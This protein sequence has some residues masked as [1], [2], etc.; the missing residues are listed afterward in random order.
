MANMQDRGLAP[1]RQN[2]SRT[3]KELTFAHNER[4]QVVS[5]GE[6]IAHENIVLCGS[7]GAEHPGSGPC[8]ELRCT[9]ERPEHSRRCP[10]LRH[11]LCGSAIQSAHP[12]QP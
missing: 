3:R 12:D 4:R 9:E 7:A 6:E 8:P 2:W 1:P 5:D 11:G 10:R